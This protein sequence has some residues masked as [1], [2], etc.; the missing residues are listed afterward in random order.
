MRNEAHIIKNNSQVIRDELHELRNEAH[1]S[2]NS[3][4]VL[5]NESHVI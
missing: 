5:R 2:K 4:Q 3:S 1:V